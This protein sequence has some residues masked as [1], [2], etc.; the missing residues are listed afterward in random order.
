MNRSLRVRSALALALALL[1][2]ALGAEAATSNVRTINLRGP[3]E[4]SCDWE[5]GR[6]R[7]RNDAAGLFLAEVK[8]K[9]A[10]GWKCASACK[11]D[12]LLVT[13]MAA[14]IEKSGQPAETSVVQKSESPAFDQLCGSTIKAGA[15]YP[16][17]PPA[18]L[19]ARGAAPIMLEFVCD[20]ATL[21]KPEK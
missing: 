5:L 13:H 1:V 21:P 7:A 4:I 20:C 8:C 16:A 12:E 10:A 15:P 11:G 6:A 3:G 9:V 2:A 19:D 14:R 18:L 17:P